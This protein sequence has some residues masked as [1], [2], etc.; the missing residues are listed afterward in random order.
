MYLINFIIS[1]LILLVLTLIIVLISVAYLT[2]FE[3]KILSSIHYR[4]GPNKVGFIGLMQPFSDALKLISK[5]YFYP[6][7]SN[8]YYYFIS[9]MLMFFLI[10]SLWLLYP[11]YNNLLSWYLSGLYLLSIMSMGVYGLMISGWSSNSSFSMIGAIRAIAQSISYEVIFSICML[12]CFFFIDSLNMYFL[13][14]MQKYIYNL[15]F[16]WP[17]SLIMM[18]SMLAEINRTPFDLVEGESELVSGFN[19]EYSSGGFILIF[20]SEYSS[21]LFMMFL[22]NLMYLNSNLWGIMFY[23]NLVILVYFVIWIRL[24]LPRIRYDFLMI[25]CWFMFLPMIL[26]LFMY[27]IFFL[28]VPF[29]F[30][31][32]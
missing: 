4:K 32:F 7:K 19:V 22:F 21:I 25:Y 20:L 1:N 26:I 8:Y 18:I 6:V 12:L 11:F 3:R 28:K 15:F 30:I 10:M 24:T 16:F 5:E 2:L 9:P 17:S 29:I 13:K 27:M 31:L 14:N 23:I